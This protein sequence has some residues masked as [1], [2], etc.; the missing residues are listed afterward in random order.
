MAKRE[1]GMNSFLVVVKL[2]L[3]RPYTHWQGCFDA[4]RGPREAAGIRDVFR[5]AVIGEQAAIYAVRTSHPRLVHDYIYDPAIRPAIEGSGFIIG[6]ESIA[7]CE[8]PPLG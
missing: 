4:D 1:R 8:E 3:D 5:A 2:R 6:S 7:V